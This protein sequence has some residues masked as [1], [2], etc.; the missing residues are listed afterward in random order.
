MRLL[1]VVVQMVE[2]V[3]EDRLYG[4]GW[5]AE[6]SQPHPCGFRRAAKSLCKRKLS[7][8]DTGKVMK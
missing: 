5:L 4:V 1:E 2:H 6:V 7:L 8:R 3:G